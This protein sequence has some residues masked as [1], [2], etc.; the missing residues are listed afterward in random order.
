M[1]KK[2]QKEDWTIEGQNDLEI[3]NSTESTL[4]E[5]DAEGHGGCQVN[6]AVPR[7]GSVCIN[8]L[9]TKNNDELVNV[10]DKLQYGVVPESQVEGGTLK[11]RLTKKVDS[12]LISIICPRRCTYELGL[13]NKCENEIEFNLFSREML[14]ELC[15]IM[16]KANLWVPSTVCISVCEARRNAP[17]ISRICLYG[18]DSP[19]IKTINDSLCLGSAPGKGA[20]RID[21]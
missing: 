3:L 21:E 14:L 6:S 11:T 9:D 20:H 7:G 16:E 15:N 12:N 4:L 10:V 18:D 2:T 8:Y 19:V 13:K 5:T 17:E 1:R